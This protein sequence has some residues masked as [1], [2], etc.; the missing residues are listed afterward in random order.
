MRPGLGYPARAMPRLPAGGPGW[1]PAATNPCLLA[2]VAIAA[3][4]L[5]SRLALLWRFPTFW[6]EAYYAVWVWTA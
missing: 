5:A 3:A 2:A 1:R 6:D 4:Y